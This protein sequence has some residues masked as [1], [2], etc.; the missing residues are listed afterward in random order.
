MRAPPPLQ[1][2]MNRLHDATSPYLLQHADQAIEWYP[3]GPE[4]LARARTEDQPI[5]LSIGYSACHWCHVMAHEAFADAA[6]AAA[7]NRDFVNIKV[8]REE[9]PDLDKIYQA[10]HQLLTGRSGGWPLTLFLTPDRQVPFF[11]GTYFPRQ[12]RPGQP[13]FGDVLARIATAYRE[14]RGQIA[15]YQTE[16]QIALGAALDGGGPGGAPAERTDDLL[17]HA[18]Q[19]LAT[20]FDQ[21]HG[22]FGGAPKFPH[23]QVLE[24]LLAAHARAPEPA[25][26]RIVSF[27]LRAMAAGGLQDHV[28]GGFYRYSTDVGWS[29]PHFE[30]MLYDNAALLALYAAA[31]LFDPGPDLLAVVDAT[32]DWLCDAMQVAAGGFCSSVD[33]DSDG[34]EGRFYVWT[35]AEVAA[36]L[37]GDDAGFAAQ[38][39]LAGPPNFG[40]CWHL[41]RPAPPRD[42]SVDGSAGGAFARPRALLLAARA[43]RVP[44][45]RDDKILTAWNALAVRALA[46]SGR[47]CER[48]AHSVA[49]TAAID[50][51]RVHHWRDGRLLATSRAGRAQLAA[52]LDDYAFLL[53]ALL[54]LLACRWRAD[55]LAFALALAEVL[56]TS[57]EDGAR[58]GFYFTAHDHETLVQRTRSFGDDALPAGNAV[59]AG[60]LARLAHLVGDLRYANSASRALAA[61][62]ADAERWPQGHATMLVASLDATEPAPLVI[63]RGD[64]GAERER[65]E[66]RAR[67][68]CGL[69]GACY[70]IARDADYL[71]GLLSARAP[72][73]G[74]AVTAYVCHGTQCSAPLTRYAEFAALCAA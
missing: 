17:T 73:V 68:Y 50:F 2:R 34:E 31:T 70:S 23:P 43:Q 18:L 26:L 69:R 66:R 63:L 11:G 59:A 5:L 10:A 25:L 37:G 13:G 65:W 56:L 14:H 21:R 29:I 58:G 36:V 38:H 41:R 52:Y 48:P 53:A 51:L 19:T 30:K 16:M 61:A 35:A 60:G 45:A 9:R 62:A 24:L 12:P 40:E 49:A 1:A 47:W 42:G 32:A 72:L 3:W 8:D 4:A 39:G 71:P 57:F 28:G 55:D 67:H 22:G 6:I 15:I 27:T 44:P 74:A 33:A 54:E 64:A 46:R 7:M 20:S